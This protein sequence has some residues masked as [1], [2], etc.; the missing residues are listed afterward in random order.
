M[1][2][3]RAVLP[4]LVRD[5]VNGFCVELYN[6]Q[7]EADKIKYILDPMHATEVEEMRVRNKAY[8]RAHAWESLAL[9]TEQF[10]IT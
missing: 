8:G 10:Y 4:H 9:A 5:G 6:F 1:V 3:D 2:S 7:A